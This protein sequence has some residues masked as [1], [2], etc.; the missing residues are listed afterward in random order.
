MPGRVLVHA[1]RCQRHPTAAAE[2]V[3]IVTFSVVALPRC[4]VASLCTRTMTTT[5][6]RVRA[7]VGVR[8]LFRRSIT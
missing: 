5:S 1:E 3:G 2:A 4:P 7:P 6:H 8:H